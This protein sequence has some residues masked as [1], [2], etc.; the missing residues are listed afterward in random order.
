MKLK[1]GQRVVLHRPHFEAP[2]KGYVSRIYRELGTCSTVWDDE[3]LN[4][5]EDNWVYESELT[6]EDIF[7]S[8]LYQAL[9]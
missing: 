8:P 7:N 6:S 2:V 3:N 5:E 9:T 4:S 1:E